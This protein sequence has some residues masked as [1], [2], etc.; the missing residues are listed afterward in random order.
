[1]SALADLT[2]K[3]NQPIRLPFGR[4]AQASA[5][6]ARATP[7][8]QALSPKARALM[9][10]KL[11]TLTQV[12]P[13]AEALATLSRQPGPKKQK[14]A[15]AA[16]HRAL[17]AGRPLAEALP[18]AAFPAD[19]RATVAAGE[20]AGR[21]PAL[22]ARL[23]DMLE[24]DVALRGRMLAALAYP[25]LLLLV[26]VAVVAAMLAFVV[27]AI[28]EQLAASGQQLPAITRAVLA[29]S[30]ALNAGWPLL[31]ILLLA[32][33]A[34]WI[35][36]ARDPRL[37]LARDRLLIR[38]PVIG[39]WLAELEAVRWARLMA[40]M[41]AAGLPAAEALLLAAPGLRNAAWADATRRM[42]AQVR[43]GQPLSA[44]LPLLPRAPDILV[45]LT[46]SGEAA[47]RLAPLLDS[48]ATTLDRELADRTR[49]ALA[50]VEPA[51]IVLLGGVV[52]LI[53]LSVLLPILQLNTLAGAGL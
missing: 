41:T 48:A 32:L 50:L 11:A 44:G 20:A 43:A 22:L 24:A 19:V 14:A 53:I 52:G 31:L 25:A 26:A 21:L 12:M 10:R 1:M 28:A 9:V 47:G 8:G 18:R 36:A 40:T 23:A 6:S 13:V 4:A 42:A 39:A 45:A 35:A 2:R 5:A 16:T 29:L 30:A 38:L 27:P 37:R 3:L 34:G 51:V 7:A 17:A 49:A 33:A 15:L 46:R